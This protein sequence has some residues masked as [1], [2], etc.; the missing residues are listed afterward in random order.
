MRVHDRLSF[1][2]ELS[3]RAARVVEGSALAQFIAEA[4]PIMDADAGPSPPVPPEVFA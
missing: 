4:E 3:E 2:D 1:R